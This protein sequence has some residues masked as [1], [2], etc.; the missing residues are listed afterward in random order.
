M[1][2]PATSLAEIHHQAEELASHLPPL[3]VAAER[4]AATVSQGVHGRR[5]VGQGETFWQFKRYEKG[6][7]VQWID[8]RQTARLD[9]VYIREME[10]EAAQSVWFWRDISP[11]MSYRSLGKLPDKGSRADLLTL[12]LAV[13]LV[14]A[15]ERVALMGAGLRPATGKRA[16]LHMVDALEQQRLPTESLPGTQDVPRHGRVVLMGDFLS[17]LDEVHQSLQRFADQGVAGHVVQLLDP[18]E[19]T[20]P[21]EGRI[22]FE[23]AEGEGLL[24]IGRV[25]SVREA[26]QEALTHHQQ[27]LSALC[28]QLGWTLT[29]HAT[30]QSPEAVLMS[31]YLL[32]TETRSG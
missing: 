12:A 9:R 10:W 26:Y 1:A 30:D 14:R 28:R 31:L 22:E 19:E 20:L 16:L 13:L 7:P 18:A 11:S 32:L 2:D 5:R 23:G 4:V 27:G 17:P 6:D 3:L 24:T 21:F 29:T 15:G 25:E 8:W